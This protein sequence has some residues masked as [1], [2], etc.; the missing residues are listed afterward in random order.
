MFRFG[1]EEFLILYALVAL[2]G[3]FSWY[4]FR[5]RREA[6]RR[7]GNQ[8]LVRKLASQVSPAARKLRVGLI[9]AVIVLLVTALARPQFGSRIE[10]VRREGQDVLIV[11]DVSKSML[12][13]DIVPNRLEKA[14]H[15]IGTLIGSLEGDRVGLVAFAGTAFVQCPLTLDYGAARMF[16]NA[17]EPDLIPVAGT[18]VGEALEKAL[19][20]FGEENRKH[21]VVVLITDGEDHSGDA[22]EAA[23]AA[24]EQGVVIHTVGIGSTE[25]V[26]IPDFDLNGRRRGFKKDRSGAV[27]M[28]RLDESTLQRIASDSGGRYFRASPAESELDLLAAEIGEMEK[29]E[30]DAREFTQYEE[31][32]QIFLGFALLLLALESFVPERRRVKAQWRGRFQ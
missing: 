32:Y 28:T 24:A 12:A 20:A 1:F 23:A 3:L 6:L 17:M 9:L 22:L 2:V 19:S 18:A 15:A 25:G 13:E 7:F 31:Q 30:L 29:Q 21:R 4:A 5:A 27:V 26:P 8:E 16:L 10:T 11:L 14:K